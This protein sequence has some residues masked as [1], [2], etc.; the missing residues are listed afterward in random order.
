MTMHI[1]FAATMACLLG[2]TS[3]ATAADHKMPAR[4]DKA[5]MR[6][7]TT[8][9]R[10]TRPLFRHVAEHPLEK[11]RV[12][13]LGVETSPVS[14]TLTAQ[15][16]LQKGAGLVV[17]HVVPKSPAE[18]VLQPHDILLK[19]ND[20][21]LIET[22]QLSVL[23]RNQKEG[24]EIAL[25]YLR[26]GKENTARVK[27]GQHEVPKMSAVG[28]DVF[29]ADGGGN[30]YMD[31]VPRPLEREDVDRMLSVVP[32]LRDGDSPRMII[33]HRSGPG[34][35][36]M[37]LNA[38]NSKLL[39]NDDAGSLEL[40]MKDGA[41]SLIAKN[42]KGEEL[43]S[44]PVT[45]EEERKRLPKEVRERLEQLEGMHNI[46]FRTDGDFKGGETKVFRPLGRGI[47]LPHLPPPHR[48]RSHLF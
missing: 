23:I 10:Q 46:T 31:V 34:F 21:L 15:L 33:G 8:P 1:R 13:F 38:E 16:G 30:L 26:A 25:T 28:G 18:G 42:A 11:E 27:L 48:E 3:A 19:F 29:R 17:S 35:R 14:P 44:G 37:S 41:R 39:F 6:V 20:Q 7:I 12:T 36:A 22:R 40:T 32:K 45:T 43:F 47:S 4:E 24:D 2:A 5:G 9:E